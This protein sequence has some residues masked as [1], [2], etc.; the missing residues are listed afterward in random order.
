MLSEARE[1]I[2]PGKGARVPGG[3]V[4]G[5]WHAGWA[6]ACLLLPVRNHEQRRPRSAAEICLLKLVQPPAYFR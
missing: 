3:P 4:R 5:E 2:R 1:D 6:E